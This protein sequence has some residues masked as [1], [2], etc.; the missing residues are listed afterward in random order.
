MDPKTAVETTQVALDQSFIGTVL[1]IILGAIL[2]VIYKFGMAWFENQKQVRAGQPS[3]P[4]KSTPTPGLKTMFNMRAS[5]V[6]EEAKRATESLGERIERLGKKTDAL[7]EDLFRVMGEH[8]KQLEVR[9]DK[10]EAQLRDYDKENTRQ[11]RDMM[12]MSGRISHI[13]GVMRGASTKSGATQYVTAS[14]PP[15]T[16]KD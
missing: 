5:E 10:V 6:K 15:H 12:G 13:E 7:R 8:R 1:A 11:D 9:L 2:F 4:D 3:K 16:N 14:M